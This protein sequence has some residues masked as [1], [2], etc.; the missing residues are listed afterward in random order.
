MHCLEIFLPSVVTRDRIYFHL[1]GLK[2]QRTDVNLK[3]N[4]VEASPRKRKPW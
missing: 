3:K 4:T 1:H 2:V